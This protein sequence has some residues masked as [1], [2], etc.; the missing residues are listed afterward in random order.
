MTRQ[1][2]FV[3]SDAVEVTSIAMENNHCNGKIYHIGTQDEI[4]IETL[5]RATGDFSIMMA[6]MR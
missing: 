5:I 6:N 3:I 4:T 2:H 1:E